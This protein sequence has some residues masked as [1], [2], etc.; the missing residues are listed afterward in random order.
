MNY[1]RIIRMSGSIFVREFIKPEKARKKVHY[2]EVDEKTVAEQFLKG[3]ATVLV[4][5][6]DSDR[7]P[8]ML[9]LESDQELI[10]KYLGS[11][12]LEYKA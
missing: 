6:E 1:V 10:K 5:F 12:F 3:D 9:D 8:I 7:Q 11:K 2:R 4:E